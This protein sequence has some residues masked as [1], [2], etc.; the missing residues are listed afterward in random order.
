MAIEDEEG[1]ELP[2]G[3]A[4]DPGELFSG[5]NRPT[6]GLDAEEIARMT[7]EDRARRELRI[8]L[9]VEPEAANTSEPTKNR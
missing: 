5:D 7:S 9:E 6:V 1:K 4:R 8:Q 3:E 2:V